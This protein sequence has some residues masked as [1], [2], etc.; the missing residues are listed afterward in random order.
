VLGNRLK[1][2]GSLGGT[3]KSRVEKG[4]D[5]L[6]SGAAPVLLFSGGF[7]YSGPDHVTEAAQMKSY[8]ISI[9]AEETAILL[10]ERSRDTIGNAFHIREI[11]R[12]HKW[13]AIQL[14][15]SE[16]HLDRA[17]YIFCRILSPIRVAT[18]SVPNA[19]SGVELNEVRAKEGRAFWLARA[20]V[21]LR[22]TSVWADILSL[23][24]DK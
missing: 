8:A 14:V 24:A 5:L 13:R 23:G 12:L 10:E 16:S 3:S 1:P 2:D 9:G 11:A 21:P 17:V 22:L 6:Q 19:L 15:T 4:V 7:G 18:T 20:I